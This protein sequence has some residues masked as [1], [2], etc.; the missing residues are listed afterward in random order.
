MRARFIAHSN[1]CLVGLTPH[2]FCS[3][4]NHKGKENRCIDT[5]IVG[6]F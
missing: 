3:G 1:G 6:R 4:M 5:D 2:I